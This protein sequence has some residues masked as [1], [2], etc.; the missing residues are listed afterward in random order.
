MEV[1]GQ[2]H[3]LASLPPGYDLCTHWLGGWVGPRIGLDAVLCSLAGSR[4]PAVQPGA[5]RYT[6]FCV[7]QIDNYLISGTG[8]DFKDAVG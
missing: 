5:C 2:F 1:S 6:D 8:K 4:T 3:T 7:I